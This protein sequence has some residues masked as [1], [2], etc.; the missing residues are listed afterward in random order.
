MN[1][2]P[3]H[4]HSRYLTLPP[5]SKRNL[6]SIVESLY[7]IKC[8]GS[9]LCAELIKHYAMKAYR[10]VDVKTHIFLISALAGGEWLASRPGRFT[11]GERARCTSWVDC[12]AGLDNMNK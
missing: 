6:V 12:R 7:H 8:N 4:I 1:Q 2:Q 5:F 9:C 11:P 10:G 3:T